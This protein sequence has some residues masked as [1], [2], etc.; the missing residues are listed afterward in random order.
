[1]WEGLKNFFVE[2]KDDFNDFKEWVDDLKASTLSKV[3]QERRK[4]LEKRVSRLNEKYADDPEML[5]LVKR[6]AQEIEEKYL[7]IIYS[8]Q[9]HT[10]HELADLRSEMLDL[11]YLEKWN[12]KKDITKS[13]KEW[14]NLYERFKKRYSDN[15]EIL[16]ILEKE[17]KDVNDKYQE[18]ISS[19]S[20]Q[21]RWNLEALKQE[22]EELELFKDEK[23]LE[24]YK[25]AQNY[26]TKIKETWEYLKE[27]YSYSETR[28][29]IIKDH[30]TKLSEYVTFDNFKD[31]YQR[32]KI[33][34]ILSYEEEATKLE[35]FFNYN[36]YTEYERKK[37]KEEDAEHLKKWWIFSTETA[38]TKERDTTDK[39]WN[40][41]TEFTTWIER[42]IDDS[43]I[44]GYSD[45]KWNFTVT[46]EQFEQ[47]LR[48]SRIWKV[49]SLALNNYLEKTFNKFAWNEQEFIQHLLDTLWSDQYNELFF[50]WK[51]AWWRTR[52]ALEQKNPK[53]LETILNWKNFISS[54]FV[55]EQCNFSRDSLN[56]RTYW[57]FSKT[58]EL[59]NITVETNWCNSQTTNA[60]NLYLANFQTEQNLEKILE[61][62]NGD[63]YLAKMII[64]VSQ[65]YTSWFK[66]YFETEAK[67]K[68]GIRMH[69]RWR[70]NFAPTSEQQNQIFELVKMSVDSAHNINSNLVAIKEKPTEEEI[71]KV[72]ALEKAKI[73]AAAIFKAQKEKWLLDNARNIYRGSRTKKTTWTSKRW[74]SWEEME[75][76]LQ[77]YREWV[78]KELENKKL[79]EQKRQEEL[80]KQEKRQK[81]EKNRNNKNDNE[82]NPDNKE[83]EKETIM[84]TSLDKIN[85]NVFVNLWMDAPEVVDWV[86]KIKLE[87]QDEP[88]VFESEKA[89]LSYISLA[90]ELDKCKLW[91]F[92]PYLSTIAYHTNLNTSK[93]NIENGIQRSEAKKF[94][95]MVQMM[96]GIYDENNPDNKDL[97]LITRNIKLRFSN[98]AQIRELW[99]ENWIMNQSTWEL[100]DSLIN[101]W[102]T[103]SDNRTRLAE[104]KWLYEVE[105]V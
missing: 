71:K 52:K 6:E 105:E 12:P 89:V 8:T 39:I 78:K 5:A 18:M 22:V 76:V 92:I 30:I 85:K 48:T 100:S 88:Q 64:R 31:K 75:R 17:Y 11:K 7:S 1:M 45:E 68:D 13:F 28:V 4:H 73:D 97:D 58:S 94:F 84:T 14:T 72:E 81:E 86:I 19:Q 80:E 27:K 61:L 99:K 83:Q 34:N 66:S 98:E 10:R 93:I 55:R 90:Q 101:E 65:E 41:A 38:E 2:L 54:S 74:V 35:K 87:W 3:Y 24:N 33:L 29:W 95:T 102:F 91:M 57:Q 69:Y 16:A 47:E 63:D 60:E 51:T 26:I 23:A 56:F 104:L 44:L 36:T 49:N 37:I 9:K 62:V 96:L 77:I 67:I 70:E 53:I 82:N 79:E 42:K 21:T 43:L 46:T 59:T 20:Q 25:E 40:I 103:E 50:L 32:K 15:P